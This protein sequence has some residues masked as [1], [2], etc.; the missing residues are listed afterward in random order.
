MQFFQRPLRLAQGRIPQ[1]TFCRDKLEQI[2]SMLSCGRRAAEVVARNPTVRGLASLPAEQ[3][4]WMMRDTM[5]VVRMRT[6]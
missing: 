3:G 1:T 2:G 6:T 4:E 5:V